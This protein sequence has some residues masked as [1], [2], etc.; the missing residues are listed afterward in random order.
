[1]NP[2]AIRALWPM[3][4]PGIPAKEKPVTSN[5]QSAVTV[6][7]CRPTWCQMPGTETPR[8]GSL[9]SSG[10]PVVVRLGP[11][12]QELEPIPSPVPSR[13]VTLSTDCA[14]PSSAAACPVL[15]V[16]TAG[17]AR[18]TV[19]AGP[20]VSAGGVAEAARPGCQSASDR[21]GSC[22]ADGYAGYSQA[23]AAESMIPDSRARVSSA[24][25]LLRRSHA[26]ALSQDS[27][28]SAVHFSTR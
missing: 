4:T 1:M 2:H 17:A 25:T 28:S 24:S 6:R 3:T 11:T 18:A 7:Q 10:F 9:A 19:T 14:A 13:A 8:C 23:S 15:G 21:I 12:T 5:G 27:E 16:G 22:R 26:I 20:D